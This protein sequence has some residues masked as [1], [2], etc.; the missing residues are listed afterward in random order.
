MLNEKSCLYEKISGE[1]NL[2]FGV[3]Y[4]EKLLTGNVKHLSGGLVAVHTLLGW[5][6]MDKAP[7]TNSSL[8]VLSLQVNDAKITDLWKLDTLGIEDCSEKRSKLEIKHLALKHLRK[9]G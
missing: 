7:S 3:D 9:N 6:V 5:T 8:L 1:I 2:L 4:V